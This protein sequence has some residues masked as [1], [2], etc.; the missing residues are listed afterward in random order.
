MERLKSF[1]E[2]FQ[3]QRRPGDFVFATAFMVFALVSLMLLPQ[4]TRWVEKT[5]VCP[6]R[7][8][9]CCGSFYDGRVRRNTFD[10]L[11]RL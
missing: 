11:N 6:A 2:L 4:E 5:A 9:A 7:I 10:R 3:R 1:V 8:L